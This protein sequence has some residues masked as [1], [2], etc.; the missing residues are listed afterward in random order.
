MSPS[1]SAFSVCDLESFCVIDPKSKRSYW[2]LLP[3]DCMGQNKKLYS[4]KGDI[5]PLYEGLF[6]L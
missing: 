1:V 4:G 3:I 2:H 5:Q 6:V